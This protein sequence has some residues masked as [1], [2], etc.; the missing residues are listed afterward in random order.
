MPDTVIVT[1]AD[2][3]YFGYLNGLLS[4]IERARAGD[5]DLLVLDVGLSSGQLAHFKPRVTKVIAPDWD[6]D[7]PARP[8]MPSWFR[9]MTARPFIPKYAQGY[10]RI[11]WLDCDTWL[12]DWR[13]IDLLIQGSANGGM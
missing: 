8:T 2:E 5:I 10:D 6:L 11:L 1:A 9:A 13:V 7:F 4:S 3:A 12:Q